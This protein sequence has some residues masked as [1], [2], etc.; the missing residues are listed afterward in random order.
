[1]YQK[2]SPLAYNNIKKIKF[3]T[4]HFQ[5]FLQKNS[6]R[7]FSTTLFIDYF[8]YKERI[9]LKDSYKRA[10]GRGRPPLPHFENRKKCSNLGK[11]ALCSSLGQIFYSKCSFKSRRKTPKF[12]LEERFFLY[13]WRNAYR[14]ALISR[15]PPALKNVWLR[16]WGKVFSA[17]C[18]IFWR[19]FSPFWR[20][21]MEYSV[22]VTT[23]DAINKFFL[24]LDIKF[25][26]K[27]KK[28]IK[29]RGVG[30]LSGL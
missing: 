19:T 2:C 6:K 24:A 22:F 10:R 3:F 14:S 21:E 11:K 7:L 29:G 26:A 17:Y 8:R 30:E 5:E 16:A 20:N 28:R 15:N 13:F 12:F 4:G 1:M 18:F 23:E 9:T 25:L 27:I